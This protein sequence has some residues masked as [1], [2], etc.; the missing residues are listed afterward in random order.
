MQVVA[1]LS[2][3][4]DAHTFSL[5][6]QAAQWF[7]D[8]GYLVL[9]SLCDEADLMQIREMLF[10]FFHKKIGHEEGRQ[11]DML[12]LDLDV[13]KMKQP[14]IVNP[15][16][17]AP[18]L[19]ETAYFRKIAA[20][21]RQLLGPKA[22]FSFDH[23]ILKPPSS[24]APTPWHQDEAHHRQR[25][26]RYRQ[27]SFWMPL[28]NTRLENGCMRYIPR[29]HLGPVLPHRPLNNDPRI[30]AMECEPEWFDASLAVAQPVD[31]GACILHDGRTLHGALPNTSAES[32]V[33][34]IIAWVGPPLLDR[35]PRFTPSV[36]LA[37]RT[38]Q[39]ERRRRWL[40]RGGFLTT[41]ARRIRQGVRTQPAVLLLK[42]RLL[43][44][45]VQMQ[46]RE[47]L[48]KYAKSSLR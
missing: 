33:A 4:R 6:S 7:A 41:I 43:A 20:I 5:P 24:A 14:Q 1:P 27:I 28:Q 9:P 16:V 10:A 23:S 34:Y 42:A 11:F 30:H 31:A 36:Q 44:K 48:A 12:G 47:A 38:A 40:L 46:M 13:S 35:T 19:L 39:M 25:L 2:A 3:P 18:A 15:S 21:A 37:G 8:E 32:R 22:Q 17:L 45:A 29:S 26:F